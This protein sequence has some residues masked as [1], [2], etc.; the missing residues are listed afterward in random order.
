MV[1]E[2]TD[3]RAGEDFPQSP[4]VSIRP[5]RVDDA[6]RVFEAVRE[7]IAEIS[8][9]M[10]WCHPGYAIEETRDWIAHCGGVWRDGREFNFVIEDRAGAFLG[11]CGLNQIRRGD[12]MANLG[13]WV[14]TSAAG[15]GVATAGVRCLAEFAFGAAGLERLEII[16]AVGNVASQRVAEKCGARREGLVSDRL[17]LRGVRHPAVAFVLE[18]GSRRFSPAKG[19]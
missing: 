13:Y 6:E 19:D 17:F 9:W 5:Y 2:G 11:A 14:R 12:R 15:R 16:A 18:R 8:P 3:E 1:R 7:S 10:P 4:P